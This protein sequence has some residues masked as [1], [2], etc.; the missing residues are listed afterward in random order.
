MDGSK[1]SRGVWR[2]SVEMNDLS[3]G[4]LCTDDACLVSTAVVSHF[5]FQEWPH[6][7]EAATI[8][9][10]TPITQSC[11]HNQNGSTPERCV[12]E[13][14]LDRVLLLTEATVPFPPPGHAF[15]DPPARTIGNPQQS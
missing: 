1:I 4:E 5:N 10:P 14:I 6:P 13:R 8:A 3:L 15:R 11:H 2:G 12:H 9:K 7:G